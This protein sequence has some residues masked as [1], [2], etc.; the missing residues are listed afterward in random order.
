MTASDSFPPSILPPALD[1]STCVRVTY[2]AGAVDLKEV[3]KGI[4]LI[5]SARLNVVHDPSACGPFGFLSAP[6]E[7]RKNEVL[8]GLRQGNVGALWSARGGYGTIRFL[9]ELPENALRQN[10][11][12]IVGYSDITA[13]HLWAN[14]QGI[15]SLHAPLVSGLSRHD[16]PT[17]E[18]LRLVAG[19]LKGKYLSKFD[20]LRPLHFGRSTGRLIGGNL[21]LLQSLIGTK[22][23]PNLRDAILLIEDVGEPAY[24]I[25]RM[26]TSLRLDGRAEGI[27]GIVFG[28]FHN[29]R[30]LDGQDAP[31]LLERWTR[32]F[33]CPV[34][35][36]LPIGHGERNYPIVLG[37][38]YDLDAYSG[39]LV[40]S[41]T[42][43][44]EATER[45]VSG[46]FPSASHLR[47]P[48]E[49]PD[50]PGAGWFPTVRV[51][52]NA[53]TNALTELLREGMASGL[54]LVASK[55][56]EVTHSFAMGSTAVLSDAAIAPVTPFTR[57]DLASVSKAIGTAVI[58]H[59]LMESGVFAYDTQ[60]TLADGLV[61]DVEELLSHRS[62]IKEWEKFYLDYRRQGVFKPPSTSWMR[63]QLAAV[64]MHYLDK[65]SAYSDIGYMLLG[66]LIR[67]NS[68]LPMD[69]LFRDY[70]SIPLGLKRTGYQGVN[71]DSIQNR[72]QFAAT[73][74]CHHRQ[75]TLQGIVHDENCQ[76]LNGVAG[77]AGLFST[78]LEVDRIARS[79][80]GFGPQI[81]HKETIRHMW[82]KPTPRATPASRAS[83][84][85]TNQ[86]S[87]TRGWDTPSIVPSNAGSLMT[88]E[89]TVGHLGFAGTSL[90][91]DRERKIAI[92][93]LTNRVHPTRENRRISG[94]RPMIHDLVMRELI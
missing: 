16:A 88:P 57:F 53:L 22:W 9:D 91:I 28:E 20:G 87:F 35:M 55:D 83:K 37:I 45:N 5:Q 70:V 32:E 58:A 54:Q 11:K 33:G 1:N 81:L 74:F 3:Q 71:M 4:A 89:R 75:R 31:N 68:P 6:D 49:I 27:K 61:T 90:W 80:L 85:D 41:A 72:D 92:T 66:E 25:D 79:L 13:L 44:E 64:K 84:L 86:G 40:P 56:G 46:E 76:L 51:H 21:T 12:W 7:V 78:A 73:E 65:R 30:G 60:V 67:T 94:I 17:S 69:E 52:G 36:G 48:Q 39:T 26:L 2:D 43:A 50:V 14:R 8:G 59:R 24:R 42:R 10:P 63:E 23:L 18:E 34:L 15:A 19:I 93:F 38:D 77:H 82:E 29:C 47:H 62:G